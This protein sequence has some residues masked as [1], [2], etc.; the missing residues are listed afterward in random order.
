MTARSWA[1]DGGGEGVKQISFREC[2][3]PKRGK[4][5]NPIPEDMKILACCK[6]GNVPRKQTAVSCE[7]SSESSNEVHRETRVA[8]GLVSPVFTV[9]GVCC[10]HLLSPHGLQ[11]WGKV[12]H[13]SPHVPPGKLICA[14][15]G[16]CRGGAG[17]PSVLPH[18]T[19]DLT[20]SCST[21]NSVCF[22]A[23]VGDFIDFP[24]GD[25]ILLC[26]LKL[27]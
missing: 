10:P 1:L 19:L 7:F 26:R 18:N 16:L 12:Q 3:G 6:A 21:L 15:R 14:D 22:F 13:S 5:K 4:K 8:C 25:G 20:F 23:W 24:F 27:A 9:Q 11:E 17:P 2:L